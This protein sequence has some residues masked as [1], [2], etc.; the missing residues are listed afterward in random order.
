MALMLPSL[1]LLVVS[2][3]GKAIAD[4]A[5]NAT[6]EQT[7][8]AE[9]DAACAT[10]REREKAKAADANPTPTDAGRAVSRPTSIAAAP[11]IL[12]AARMAR[13]ARTRSIARARSAPTGSV[14]RSK[15]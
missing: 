2:T 4:D 15:R 7:V 5:A 8:C 14:C 13:R 10:E 3:A 12:R 6:G 9:G 11:A 1:D